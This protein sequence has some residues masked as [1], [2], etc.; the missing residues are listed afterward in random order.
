MI[1]FFLG[2]DRMSATITGTSG[3]D[4]LTSTTADETLL[5]GAG[6]DTYVFE[7]NFGSDIISGEDF[8]QATLDTIHFGSGILPE[9]IEAYRDPA[10]ARDLILQVGS[11]TIRVD[12]QYSGTSTG[13]GIFGNIS[14]ITFEDSPVVLDAFVDGLGWTGTAGND[15]MIGSLLD[16]FFDGGLGNDTILGGNGM[17][18]LSGSEG[19]DSISGE[20]GADFLE[21]GVGN[22]TLAGGSGEDFYYFEQGFGSDFITG[23]DFSA[24][25]VDAI[26]L[27]TGFLP[28]DIQF[29]RDPTNLRDLILQFSSGDQIIIDDQYTGPGVG[30]GIYGQIAGVAFF[31]TTETINF[32]TDGLRWEGTAGDDNIIG[33]LLADNIG[34]GDGNDTLTLG[35]GDDTLTGGAGD[36]LLLGQSGTDTYVFELGFGSDTIT[37][38]DFSSVTED[39]IHFGSGILP[40]DLQ[41]YRDA[42]NAR[43]LIVQVGADQI[44][45]DDQYTGPFSTNG[46]YAN[47]RWITF[48]DSA[49][50]LDLLTTGLIWD[51]TP[52]DDLAIG[53]L[54]DDNLGGGNG[55][56]T[57]I[58]G[59]GNDLLRGG[60][61]NDSISGQNDDDTLIG[62]AG[63]DTLEGGSGTDTYRFF[64]GFGSDIIT[65]ED[66]SAATVDTIFLGT[67]FLPGD[68]QY[69]RDPTNQRDLI[70]QF[71]GGEQIMIDDQYTGPGVGNGIYG[72]I[73]QVQFQDSVEIID[74]LTD[75]LLW[76]GSAGN[77]NIIG[78]LL[79]D[80]VGG[81]DG[82]DT[83]TTGNGDDT[84]TGGAGDDLLQG[85]SGTD[86]YVF[87]LGFGSD[88]IT[89]E[90]FSQSTLDT[91]HFGAGILPT[92][93]TFGRAPANG[94]DLL[95]EVGSNRIVVDDQFTGPFFGSGV[96]PQISRITFEDSSEVILP[97]ANG[98]IVWPGAPTDDNI[99]GTSFND[100]LL[101]ADGNDLIVAEGG[102]DTL[103]GGAG[104]D[105]IRAGVGNDWV[106]AGD[107]NDTVYAGNGNDT[108]LGGAGDDFLEGNN[109]ADSLEGGA[110]N[111]TLRS[112][113]GDDYLDGGEG[114][115]LVIGGDDQD[116]LF[117]GDGNDELNGFNGD[118]YA[119][120]GAGDDLVLG[121]SGN[122]TLLGGGGADTIRGEGANDE[123]SGGDGNDLIFGSS[124]DD[125]LFG[126]EGDDVIEGNA[127]SDVLFGEAGNDT[128]RGGDGFDA[129][130]GGDG[131][132]VLVGGNGEDTLDGGTGVDILRGFAGNDTFV[133]SAT[134]DSA[135]GASDLIDGIDGVGV[136][137]GDR[138]DLSAIDADT[139]TAGDQA[140]LFLGVLTTAQGLAAGPGAL[141]L[142]D[143][144]GQTRVYGN[145]DGDGTVDLAIRINDGAVLAADYGAGEFM[146]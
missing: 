142:E 37:G 132:D 61:G 109:D 102:N 90:D 92:D 2:G 55:A 39:T 66:F 76:E 60:T 112:N 17:D 51:G 45:I 20:N 82:N 139:G 127:Q 110:G 78:S 128:L 69:Y 70:L 145:V 56:D 105:L 54:T 16:D 71:G 35:S 141:W 120:A 123:I 122:D 99:F 49:T 111:D 12:D 42:A 74:F 27:D 79:A 67:G 140:F 86:T 93:I 133:F 85:N 143:V 95:I 40:G 64:Q 134:S 32:L 6:T 87:E 63:N 26:F 98:K 89:G 13:N 7:V 59:S 57:L 44:L 118:D 77:D 23:E 4:T 94:R 33:S 119:D 103:N 11:N 68:I 117:G 80:D 29:Y 88:T 108:L 65:G 38:E 135:F 73:A 22:D 62:G 19:D 21:G 5:G 144:G 14:R 48:E 72:Q 34:G 104:N 36:D 84:L 18:D 24:A 28:G 97:I 46:N 106:D 81:G 43:D 83:I 96:Y 116:T 1:R 30:N 91:I 3:N 125:T 53:A 136:A 52:G 146:L 129:L 58:G 15:L 8:T 100:L 114:N 124:G 47:I 10:N 115:D 130:D 50:A 131:D 9:D 31:D 107:G 126:G 138:I 25:T 75:G 101:G 113:R 41:I 137:G 121:G